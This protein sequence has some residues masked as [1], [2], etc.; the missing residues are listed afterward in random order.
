MAHKIMLN[1]QHFTDPCIKME[2][3]QTTT[4]IQFLHTNVDPEVIGEDMFRQLNTVLM[5]HRAQGII[6]SVSKSKK[7]C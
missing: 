2:S 1:I 5:C 6:R 3:W 7:H 4:L